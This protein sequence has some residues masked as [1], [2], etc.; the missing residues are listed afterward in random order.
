MNE[1]IGL[2]NAIGDCNTITLKWVRGHIGTLGNEVADDL[3]KAGA[4]AKFVG[5]EPA[6]GVSPAVVLSSIRGISTSKHDRHWQE[7]DSCRQAKEFG[8]VRNP[9]KARLLLKL[10]RVNLRA[11]MCLL[12]GHGGFNKHLTVMG[13]SDSSTCPLC[14][15]EEDTSA[16][17]LCKCEAVHHKRLWCLGQSYLEPKDICSVRLSTLTRFLRKTGRWTDI[18]GIQQA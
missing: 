6:V 17:L 9:K 13:L 15:Q 1:C 18:T 2:L 3:A 12:T 5:P 14:G 11:A 10:S 8:I 16:H 4:M 7:L